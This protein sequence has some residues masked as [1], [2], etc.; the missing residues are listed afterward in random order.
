MANIF[1]FVSRV[2]CHDT[3]L[4]WLKNILIFQQALKLHDNDMIKMVGELIEDKE[5][6]AIK[7]ECC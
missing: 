7:L 3:C 5:L 6:F 2:L 1:S 4:L